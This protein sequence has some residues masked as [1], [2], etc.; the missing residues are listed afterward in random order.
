MAFDKTTVFS[1]LLRKGEGSFYCGTRGVHV[2][3]LPVSADRRDPLAME[4]DAHYW[5]WSC[6]LF[7]MLFYPGLDCTVFPLVTPIQRCMGSSMWSPSPSH[8]IPLS[9]DFYFLFSCLKVICKS[10]HWSFEEKVL[11]FS[12]AVRFW[13][14][15]WIWQGMTFLVTILLGYDNIS[16]ICGLMFSFSFGKYPFINFLNKIL[17]P[18]S[19]LDF[20]YTLTLFTMTQMPLIL[21]S[22]LSIFSCYVSMWEHSCVLS[23]TVLNLY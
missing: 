4:T 13:W 14:C 20:S 6:C 7:S 12:S 3:K 15:F 11:T 18:V 21:F 16:W 1:V 19:F 23:P 5:G 9:S 10:Y 8:N 2:G 17:A 22:V